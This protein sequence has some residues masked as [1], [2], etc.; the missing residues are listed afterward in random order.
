MDILSKT[1]DNLQNIVAPPDLAVNGQPSKHS[2][3]LPEPNNHAPEYM[4]ELYNLYSKSTLS[5]PMSNI[6][7]SFVNINSEGKSVISIP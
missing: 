7:R 4:M 1:H 2:I 3:Q 6:V 5:H